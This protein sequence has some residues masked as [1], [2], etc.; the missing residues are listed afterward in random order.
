MSEE[1]AEELTGEDLDESQQ[2]DQTENQ[3]EDQPSEPD[4]EQIELQEEAAKYGWKPKEE[5]KLAP[6]GWVD[7]ERFLELPSTQR[8]MVQDQNKELRRELNESKAD[9][10]ARMRRLEGTSKV[11]MQ[12]AL[13]IQRQSYE[14]QLEA[15]RQK[16][17]AA[18]EVGDVDA[19]DQ[20]E[21][22]ERDL[23]KSQPSEDEPED[24]GQSEATRIVGEYRAKNDWARSPVLW[25]KAVEAVEA[26]MEV[27]AQS[28]EKQLEYA[29]TTLRK[30]YPHLFPDSDTP[31]PKPQIQKVDGGGLG[32]PRAK[33]NGVNALPPEA[34][35][36]G[37]QFVKQGLFKDLE[38]YATSYFSQ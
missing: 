4:P 20:L 26:N 38:E 24:N 21:K 28:T 29:E 14:Q 10:E 7:A 8:K 2:E 30:H 16:Q 13:E 12:R 19:Y 27:R 3:Q 1:Q 23:L 18:V 5:F 11:A 25:Q 33:P 36:E 37:Q 15:V 9:F 31:K 35:K 17:R 34:K 22:Q 32:A 6:D